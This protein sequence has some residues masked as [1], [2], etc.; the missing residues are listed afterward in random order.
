[1]SVAGAARTYPDP[2]HGRNPPGTPFAG[3]ST[4]KVQPPADSSRRMFLKQSSLG[5]A[6]AAA[7]AQLPLV[8]AGSGDGSRVQ[9]IKIGLIG[10][11]G[12]GTGATLDALGAATKVIYPSEG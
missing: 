2:P 11:G 8:H 6:G 5:V 3:A 1:M 7:A 4:M 9:E 12:R 10:C